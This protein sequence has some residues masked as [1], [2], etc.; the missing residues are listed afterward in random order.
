MRGKWRFQ[1]SESWRLDT[2]VYHVDIDNGYDA[3]SLD[4]TRTTLSDEPGF[5]RQE[6]V[7]GGI[8]VDWAQRTLDDML[9]AMRLACSSRMESMSL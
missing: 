5:D 4:N 6:T 9:D 1:A 7:A 8:Q 2:T 3:F